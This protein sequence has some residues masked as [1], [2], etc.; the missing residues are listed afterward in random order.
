MC[1]SR[2]DSVE[3][4]VNNISS[5][6]EDRLADY[7]EAY[8][9]WKT[10]AEQSIS[11]S[12]R[13]STPVLIVDKMARELLLYRNGK[14]SK[15]YPVELGVNWVGDKK[16][17]GDGSTPEGNYKVVDKKQNGQT[18][19][20]KAFLLDYPNDE[21]RLRF[22]RNKKNGAIHPDAKIGNLIEIHGS[23]GKG[24]DWTDGCIALQDS[25]MDE[26]FALCAAGTRVTIVGSTIPLDRLSYPLQ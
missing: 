17:Q 7:F 2:L 5:H 9:Y 22:A 24:T 20:H 13:N 6:Y 18:R 15:R 3:A 25:H 8:P 19:Y 1:R 21:D 23:G 14:L 10:L 26:L 12:K 11:F 16:Q 4:A